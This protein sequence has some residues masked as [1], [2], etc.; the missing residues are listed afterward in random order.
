[1]QFNGPEYVPERDQARLTSQMESIKKLMSDGKWRSLLSIA[2]ETG[3][4]TSSISAQLRHLRKERFGGH[5]VLRHHVKNGLYIYQLI[6]NEN[7]NE[8]PGEA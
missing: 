2:E 3:F 5:T 6:L 8:V 1:M 4:T 7:M